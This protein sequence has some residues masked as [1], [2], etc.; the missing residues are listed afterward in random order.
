MMRSVNFL[1][2]LAAVVAATLLV[3]PL[4]AVAETEAP[5]P[6]S[7]TPP[8][9][10]RTPVGVVGLAPTAVC[11]ATTTVRST[12]TDLDPECI[13]GCEREERRCFNAARNSYES[14]RCRDEFNECNDRCFAGE[15]DPDRPWYDPWN[16]SMPPDR[17]SGNDCAT[18][19]TEGCDEI[20]N[21]EAPR[22]GAAPRDSERPR[23]P[24]PH[25]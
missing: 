19:G 5:N 17:G 4:P 7:V 8:E 2:T 3:T 25:N 14:H 16:P 1:L 24:N 10:E 9:V 21:D 18:P 15:L 22:G 13:Y 12:T 20:R 6:P 11:G 23:R